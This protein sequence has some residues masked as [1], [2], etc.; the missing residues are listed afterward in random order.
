MRSNA[1]AHAYFKVKGQS[2]TSWSK[3]LF[4]LYARSNNGLCISRACGLVFNFNSCV[5]SAI[6][7]LRSNDFLAPPLNNDKHAQQMHARG[8]WT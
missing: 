7:Y 4:V 3:A 1:V 6:I 5:A 2:R 8:A